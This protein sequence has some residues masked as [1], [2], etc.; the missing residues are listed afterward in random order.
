VCWSGSEHGIEKFEARAKLNLLIVMLTSSLFAPNTK[1]NSEADKGFPHSGE[2]RGI[3]SLD[4]L[5]KM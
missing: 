3:C 5:K 1:R 4:K 2:M